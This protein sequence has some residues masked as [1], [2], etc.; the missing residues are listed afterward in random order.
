M[1]LGDHLPSLADATAWLN[2]PPKP[3]ELSDAPVL[4][5]FWSSDCPLCHEGAH[6]IARWRLRFAGS[7][8][9]TIAIYQLRPDQILDAS[10]AEFEARELMHLDHPCALD[11]SGAIARR[12]DSTYPPG[13]YL[14]DRSHELRHRQMGNAELERLE[15]IIDRLA[16]KAY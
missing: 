3:G 2:G 8:L 9:V 14:F 7:G 5:H 15:A 13:Y 4:L 1:K 10:A 16:V 6:A 12:F 11:G